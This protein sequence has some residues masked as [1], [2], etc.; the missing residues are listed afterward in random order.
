MPMYSPNTDSNIRRATGGAPP[1]LLSRVRVETSAPD[2]YALA[3]QGLR[4]ETNEDVRIFGAGDFLRTD[5]GDYVGLSTYVSTPT[6]SFSR[7]DTFLD[8][9]AGTGSLQHIVE[10]DDY[11]S[12]YDAQLAAAQA[13]NEA[14]AY[15]NAVSNF[16]PEYTPPPPPETYYEPYVYIPPETS[17]PVYQPQPQPVEAAPT[18]GCETWE[19]TYSDYQGVT[20]STYHWNGYEA[21]LINTVTYAGYT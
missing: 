8:N 13:E 21:N 16:T 4:N 20:V 14:I 1:D 18:G 3:S 12:D 2:S 10:G 17:A 11:L 6:G 9:G 5:R 19:D 15:A 7:N